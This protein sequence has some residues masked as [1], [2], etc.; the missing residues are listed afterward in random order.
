MFLKVEVMFFKSS[1]I[2]GSGFVRTL[3]S[4]LEV[5]WEMSGLRVV[6]TSLITGCCV[7]LKVN[8]LRCCIAYKSKVY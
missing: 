2:D 8:V 3:S 6:T 1:T 7:F 4:T 5:M